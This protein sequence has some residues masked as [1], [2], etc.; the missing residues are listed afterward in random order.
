LVRPY[1][2]VRVLV[3]R[4]SEH[5]SNM[6]ALE[7]NSPENYVSVAV[8]HRWQVVLADAERRWPDKLAGYYGPVA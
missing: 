4:S 8:W 7:S 6:M 1:T 5:C 3:K 2:D